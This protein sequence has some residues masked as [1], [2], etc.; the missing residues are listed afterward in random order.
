MRSGGRTGLVAMAATLAVAAVAAGAPAGAT[1]S[2][3]GKYRAHDYADGQ[4]M[5][6]LPPGENGLVNVLDAVKFETTGARPAHSDDQLAQYSDLLYGA[7]SLTNAKLTDYFNDESFGVKP[8]DVIRTEKPAA[9]V[10]ILRDKK[11]MPHVYGTTDADAGFGAGYAQAE[12]RLFLMDVLRHYGAGNLASFL[13]AGCDFEQMDHDQLLLSPYT[14]AQAQAQV[15]AL[16]KEYGEQGAQAKALIDSYVKGV[17]AYID[18]TRTD[19]TKLPADY[20]AGAPDA[21]VPQ[22][23]TDAD[24]VSIA[25]L[26]GGIFGK[27]GGFEVDDAHLL[28]YLQGKLGTTAGAKAYKDLNHQN[29]P[30]APTTI[31]DKSYP[32][33]VRT[34]PLDPTLNAIPDEGA[35]TGGP[36]NT[37]AGCGDGSGAPSLPAVPGFPLSTTTRAHTAKNIVGALKA[38]PS[39]MSNALV[40][41]GSQTKSGHPIAVFGPQVSYF[42]PQILSTI[43]LHSPNI[44]AEGASFPG[45]GLVELGRGEDYAWSATSA[46]SDLIDMRVEKI[47]N[48]SGGAPAKNGTSYLFKGKCLAM[49]KEQ[50]D[51]TALPKASGAG[52]PAVLK[53]TIYK[54][55]HGIVQGWTTVKGK[56]VAI[57]QQR[58][59]YNHDIDSV[60]GFLG[61]NNPNLTHDAKSWMK[62]ANKISFTFNWF[63]ADD[64]DT[65][66][67]VSG[68]DPVRNPAADPTLPTWGTGESEWTGYLTAAQHP[69]EI[70]PKQGY[71][72]SWNNK[73]APGFATDGEYPYG[74]TYRSVMLDKQL[75]K[76]MA[77]HP[78]ALQRSHVVQAME[79]AASQD[80]D[81]VELNNLILS[82][83]GNR[84]EP[85]G[86]KAMLAQL[87][88]WDA[89]GSHRIRA[90]KGDTQYADHSAVAISDELVPNLITAFY[91]SI[92]ADGGAGGVTSTGGATLPGYGK[93]PMQWVNTPNSGDAHLG[94]AYDGGYEGY[95]MSTFQQLLGQKPADGFGTE[96]TSRECTGG[97]TT[98]HAAVDKALQTTYDALVKANGSSDVASWTQSTASKASG[99]SMPDYDS[100]ILRPL[101]I[102]GQPHLD[103]QNRPTFQQVVEFPRHRTR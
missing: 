103:W 64:K 85:A 24:V 90:K 96:L 5:Y 89:S 86:V 77:A 63:Y 30:L 32:Y 13:G 47:C 27:G 33:D 65:G 48:P 62:S 67:F 87:K 79:T 3:P 36:T 23:W 29:D 31:T 11:D 28:T 19:P 49:T 2:G 35:L 26:I 44:S 16:P 52:A 76:Q 7:P 45:T 54:T 39:H 15:D 81:G 88:S 55:T 1:D 21:L 75:K 50:F 92:L 18:A 97:P 99:E 82:Y 38:M 53:H 93:L 14:K 34:K 4:A 80:L 57:V 83:V 91:D 60:V 102:V 95:L 51:E 17:N 22:K 6:V 43:D 74:Q 68:A 94:S 84:A 41:N 66:Y 98:C 40:V 12:D 25:G 10:T 72:I 46:G 61:F 71:F 42:A 73:P 69:Q 9:G 59:T 70:N 56:P 20:V 37:S 8:A 101:G 100:I 78:H 58:S